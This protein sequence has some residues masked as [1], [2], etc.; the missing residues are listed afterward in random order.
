MA[1]LNAHRPLLLAA[2]LHRAREV[3]RSRPFDRE[4]E[5]DDGVHPSAASVPCRRHRRQICDGRHTSPACVSL[6]LSRL[7]AS[8]EPP[9]SSATERRWSRGDAHRPL[10][11][12]A[13]AGD[14]SHHRWHPG[15]P[16]AEKGTVSLRDLEDDNLILLAM[17]PAATHVESVL[18]RLDLKLDVRWNSGDVETI[19]AMVA[20]PRLQHHHGL[21]YGDHT[22]AGLPVRECLEPLDGA[23]VS[24]SAL[25]CDQDRHEADGKH[26][27]PRPAQHGDSSA[28]GD[29]R[30]RDEGREA[31][32]ER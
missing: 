32:A 9:A 19:C 6:A 29:Q 13:D 30:G 26:P 23:E 3:P 15:H 18:R 11:V 21:P 5:D 1:K 2:H 25:R 10:S 28:G 27:Q 17:Q 8:L 31:R 16:L 20:R 12:R 14:A 24:R 4:T 7:E 22:H